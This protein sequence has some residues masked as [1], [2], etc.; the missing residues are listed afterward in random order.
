MLVDMQTFSDMLS[1]PSLFRDR[2]VLFPDFIPDTL[3]FRQ[4][5]IE[6]IMRWVSPALKG[7]KPH[8]VLIYGKTGTGKTACVKVVKRQFDGMKS[9]AAVAYVNCRM[10]NSRYR[11]LQKI[12][13]DFLPEKDLAGFGVLFMYEAVMDWVSKGSRH[14]VIVLDEADM[15]KDLDELVY[16]L[17]RAND[18]LKAGGVSLIGISNKLSFKETLDPRSRSSLYENEM[19]FPPYNAEQMQSILKQ[20]ADMGYGEGMVTDSAI[21]LASAIAA[22]ETG[23][24]RYGLRLLL[25]AG[26]I[27]DEKALKQITD[28]EIELARKTVELDL[29]AETINTL[30]AHQQVV[31]YGIAALSLEGGR[32]PKL[33]PT[34]EEGTFILSG[35]GYEAYAKACRQFGRKKR[36]ARWYRE[37]LHDLEMLGLLTIVESGKGMRG[38]TRLIKIAYDAA[39][40]KAL[41]EKNLSGQG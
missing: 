22:Q 18:E 14:L 26:E 10:Y 9:G 1:R 19:V 40:V 20:R 39:Q 37:Y 6:R 21:N 8:N 35:E 24:A 30:P 34:D 17:T 7:E 27:A 25:K 5:E 32:Y 16:T 29:A 28:K 33:A 15:V 3:P 2:D 4:T 38:H 11:V 13:K 36:S 12:I 23:D 31:L 41:V